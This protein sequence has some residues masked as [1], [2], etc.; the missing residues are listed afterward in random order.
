[1]APSFKDEIDRQGRADIMIVGGGVVPLQDYDAVRKAGAEAIF[2]P[3]TVIARGRRGIGAQAQP[4]ARPQPGRGGVNE[5][6]FSLK[7]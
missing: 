4:P 2:P 3:G 1:M 6:T 7:L 5:P